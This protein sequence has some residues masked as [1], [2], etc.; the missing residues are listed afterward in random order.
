MAELKKY[1]MAEDADGD[2][3][4]LKHNNLYYREIGGAGNLSDARLIVNALNEKEERDEAARKAVEDSNRDLVAAPEQDLRQVD[5]DRTRA[6]AEY[7]RKE[8]LKVT[9]TGTDFEPPI[10]FVGDN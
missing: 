4:I 10:F 2:F 7:G 5:R 8:G 1:T 9:E 6:S 3:H